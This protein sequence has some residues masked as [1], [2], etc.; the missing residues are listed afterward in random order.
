MKDKTILI[1]DQDAISRKFL[2]QTVKAQNCVAMQAASG[3]EGLILALRDRPDAIILD[4]NLPDLSGSDLIRKLRQDQRTAK[5]PIICLSSDPNPATLTACL[6]ADCNEYL[7]KSGDAVQKLFGLLEQMFGGSKPNHRQ[8]PRGNLLVF[9]SAK[10]GVGTSS[11]CANIGMHLARE[12][13]ADANLALIDLVLPIGSIAPIVGYRGSLNISALTELPVEQI[14][15][16]F[17]QEN[18]PLPG[19]WAF[20]LL[21]GSPNP[22]SANMLQV[23]RIPAIL[24]AALE[25]F[26]DVLVDLGRSLSRISLPIL[27]QADLLVPVISTDR[28]T[29]ELTKTVLEYLLAKGIAPQRFFAILNRIV[30]TEGM[31]KSA[32]EKLLDVKIMATMPYMSDNMTIANAQCQPIS[33]RFPHDTASMVLTEFTK[34]IPEAIKQAKLQS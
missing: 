10:G 5:T 21:A 16:A 32:I 13:G 19:H 17:M 11:L 25:A 14:T 6:E 26:D 4:P 22:E 3:R 31:T 15:A 23:A 24:D 12:K 9:F 1:V 33:Q 20:H 27:Q 8:Q 18:L 34:T 2:V 28:S 30:G 29:V 7:T